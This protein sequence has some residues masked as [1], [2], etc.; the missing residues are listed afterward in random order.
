MVGAAEV[1]RTA[2]DVTESAVTDTV[3][4]PTAIVGNAACGITIEVSVRVVNEAAGMT[5]EPTVTEVKSGRSEVKWVPVR[6]K[7]PVLTTTTAVVMV[8]AAEVIRVVADFAFALTVTFVVPTVIRPVSKLAGM[9]IEVA[10][11]VPPAVVMAVEESV[12]VPI[13]TEDTSGDTERNV[14]PM[15][16]RAS[17]LTATTAE[18]MVGATVRV[19]SI[20]VTVMRG[21]VE[22]PAIVLARAEMTP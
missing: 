7:I 15:M 5:V 19:G 8:G 12:V 21:Y 10:P 11:K 9:T 2:V 20:V 1:I 17:G 22:C 18:L 6:V 14:V 16:V 3:V 4:V 13:V